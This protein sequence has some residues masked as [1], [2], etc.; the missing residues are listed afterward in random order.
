MVRHPGVKPISRFQ[1][2]RHVNQSRASSYKAVTRA[3]RYLQ[4]PGANDALRDLGER[5]QMQASGGVRD[6]ARLPRAVDQLLW[7]SVHT[8]SGESRVSVS[9]SVSK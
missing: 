1:I 4:R 8:F 7:L 6:D 5:L 2:Q 3:G 9:V